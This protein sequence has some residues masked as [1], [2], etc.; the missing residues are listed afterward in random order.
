VYENCTVWWLKWSRGALRK[1]ECEECK[2][3]GA[4]VEVK[5]KTAT[6]T[7]RDG[8]TFQKRLTTNGFHFHLNGTARKLALDELREALKRA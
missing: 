8:Q 2:E 6:V 1:P 3:D 4:R 5:G 7:L